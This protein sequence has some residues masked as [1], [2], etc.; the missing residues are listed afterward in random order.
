MDRV[1]RVDEDIP[2]FVSRSVARR[3]VNTQYRDFDPLRWANPVRRIAP[4]P[5]IACH[6]STE[7]LNKKK[8]IKNENNKEKLAMVYV[9]IK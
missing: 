8:T 3:R 4:R 7:I 1:L 6:W 5:H 9:N 2:F